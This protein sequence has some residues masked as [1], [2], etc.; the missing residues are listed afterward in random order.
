MSSLLVFLSPKLISAKFN[1]SKLIANFKI[2]LYSS[3]KNKYFFLIQVIN[4][5][6]IHILRITPEVVFY[7]ILLKDGWEFFV[8]NYCWVFKDFKGFL[9]LCRDH[10]FKLNYFT[11]FIQFKIQFSHIMFSTRSHAL[12]IIISQFIEKKNVCIH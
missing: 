7:I 8:S 4:T 3:D 9:R 12:K 2:L 1:S 6:I 11:I 5:L 10:D